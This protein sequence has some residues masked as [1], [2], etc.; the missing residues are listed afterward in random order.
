MKLLEMFLTE[1]TFYRAGNSTRRARVDTL[2]YCVGEQS[3]E[4]G[5]D[6]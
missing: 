4:S 3:I 1:G 6:V 5:L 2:R